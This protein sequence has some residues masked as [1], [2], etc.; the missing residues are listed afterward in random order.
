MYRAFLSHC[1]TRLSLAVLLVQSLSITAKAGEPNAKEM[2]ICAHEARAN[3]DDFPGFTA[4]IVVSTN[5][6]VIKGQM[7]VAADGKLKLGLPKSP[8]TAWARRRLKSMI[9]HRLPRSDRKF[10][11]SF[12]DDIKTHPLG[13]LI[14]FNQ[15]RLH[16]VYRIKGD[17]I[18]EVHRTTGLTRF[19][20]SVSQVSRNAEGKILPKSYSVS[21]WDAK[22][23]NLKACDTVYNEWVRVGRLD[24]P[25][26]LLVVR[27]EDDGKRQVGQVVFRN[28]QLLSTA[29]DK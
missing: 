8:K 2:M 20:I 9:D 14:R 29:V 18:T 10:D 4:D 25:A 5:S 6:A 7:W 17:V 22:T 15:D 27:T 24:L 3:W 28:H 13:R 16:S 11:V 23:G 1:C 19:T 12:A 26:K 21:W